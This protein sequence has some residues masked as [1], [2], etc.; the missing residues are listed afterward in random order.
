M[1]R[2]ADLQFLVQVFLDRVLDLCAPDVV[3]QTAD[4]LAQP[5]HA[6]IVEAQIFVARF[7]VDLGDHEAVLVAG[8]LVG[9]GVEVRAVLDRDRLLLRSLRSLHVDAQLRLDAFLVVDLLHAHEGVVRAAVRSG[10]GHDDLLDQP[11]LEGPHRVEPVDQVVGIAVGGRVAQGAQRVQRL[12]RL[13]RLVGGS[14]RS[15]ARR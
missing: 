5:E 13:L 3:A 4:L 15:A 6:A 8:P 10:A 11:Q 2:A 14:P 7:G 1:P 12:D 9:Q